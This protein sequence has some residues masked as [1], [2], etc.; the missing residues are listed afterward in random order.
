MSRRCPAA[1]PASSE[2]RLPC[3]GTRQRQRRRLDEVQ[4]GRRAHEVRRFDDGVLGEGAG[5]DHAEDGLAGFEAVDAG[6]E[7]LD[8][9]DQ[10]A[11]HVNGQVHAQ[12]LAGPAAD[13]PVDRVHARGPHLDQHFAGRR[14][15]PIE[16][17]DQHHSLKPYSRMT[18]AFI[19]LMTASDPLLTKAG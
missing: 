4:V 18:T 16:V 2:E 5:V 3:G 10:L 11:A 12:A 14:V 17:F 8:R 7:R 9:A 15:R 6:A 19:L 1:S 13:L